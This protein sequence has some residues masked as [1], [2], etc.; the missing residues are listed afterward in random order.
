MNNEQLSARLE[1]IENRIGA[2]ETSLKILN[3]E[4]GILS[5]SVKS[6]IVPMIIKYVVFPL[7][8]V[9]GGITGVNIF[10]PA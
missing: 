1:S 8:L 5:G 10:L 9:I 7:I 2:I 3:H 4:I 6:S